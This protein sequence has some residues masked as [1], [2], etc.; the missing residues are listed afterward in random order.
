MNTR[1][2][3]LR[4]AVEKWLGF[5]PPTAARIAAHG[6]TTA[7]GRRYVCVETTHE[8]EQFA[9]FFF[10]HDDGRWKVFPPPPTLPEMAVERLAA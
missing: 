8:H 3:S 2:Q 7:G 5:K 1:D 10:R 4:H 9:L 6:R